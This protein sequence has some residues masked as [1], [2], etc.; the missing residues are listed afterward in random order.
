M[1][2]L[3]DVYE[4]PVADHVDRRRLY[5]GVGLFSLGA[6]LAVAG[7]GIAGSEPTTMW[8]GLGTAREYGAILAGLG[9]PAVFMGI[10]IVL[11]AD[12]NTRAAAVVGSGIAVLGVT[13]FSYAYPC[14][15]SGAVCP[16]VAGNLTLPVS[17]VY[18]LGL[19]VTFWCLFVSVVN[20]KSRNDPGGT[21]ELEITRGGETKVIEVP[22]SELDDTGAGGV[23]FFGDKPDGEVATQTNRPNASDGVATSTGDGAGASRSKGAGASRSQGAGANRANGAGASRSK[24]GDRSGTGGSS[25]ANR[26]SQTN[27]LDTGTDAAG[28]GTTA[29]SGTDDASSD[30]GS[31]TG[32]GFFGSGTPAPDGTGAS[33]RDTGG[34]G[35]FGSAD[36]HTDESASRTEPDVDAVGRRDRRGVTEETTAGSARSGVQSDSGGSEIREVEPSEVATSPGDSYCGSCAHFRY[37]RTDEGM[38]PYCEF[39][40][41]L[42][43]DM[44]ACPEW[45]QR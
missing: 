11:P 14:R 38:Q 40:D 9:V 31:S 16:G 37:V 25:S 44:D 10:F 29:R 21:V 12:R 42:M 17:A 7:I 41:E 28:S 22:E 39:H 5:A 43:D 13:L 36:D 34:G 23:G 18:A 24:G 15:W 20:F 35:G 6:V 3:A 1:T 30:T 27:G 8:L 19:L 32:G 4:G 2:S 33:A 26:G 45:T